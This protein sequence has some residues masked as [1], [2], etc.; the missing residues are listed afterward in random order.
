MSKHKFLLIILL[1]AILSAA[2]LIF[3]FDS[4]IKSPVFAMGNVPTL[5][6]PELPSRNNK[7]SVGADGQIVLEKDAFIKDESGMVFEPKEKDGM[8]RVYGKDGSL[9][10]EVKTKYPPE[11]I[12]V[13]GGIL[14]VAERKVLDG[15]SRFIIEQFSLGDDQVGQPS[16]LFG[17]EEKAG[18]APV[19]D[20]DDK[21]NILIVVADEK[22]GL[23]EIWKLAG[24]K[25][26][27]IYSKQYAVRSR[28][29]E[30]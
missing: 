23:S 15:E 26:E 30:S 11:D 3:Y 28:K 29:E 16:C 12:L 19:I 22:N 24:S 10:Q 25:W 13:L 2:L 17:E 21:G 9:C 8:I 14:Y 7:I 6:P 20:A 5:S 27:K 4:F 18:R 1:F